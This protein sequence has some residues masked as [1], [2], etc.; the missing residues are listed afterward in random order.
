MRLR[1][2]LIAA[3]LLTH[4]LQ[5]EDARQ[6]E[7]A[8]TDKFVGKVL[9]IRGFYKQNSLDYDSTGEPK[10]KGDPGPW[11]LYG[12]LRVNEVKVRKDRLEIQGTRLWVEWVPDSKGQRQMQLVRTTDDVLLKADLG[13][14]EP[15]PS[16]INHILSSIFLNPED[17][18][19]DLVPEHWRK[20]FGGTVCTSALPE[21]KPQ[22]GQGPGTVQGVS[23]GHLLK[24]ATPAY[25]EQA[26]R[27]RLQGPVVFD[28]VINKQGKVRCLSVW[29]PLGMGAEE[30]SL[31]A[32]RQ[33]TY[34][35]YL[36]NGQP[37]EVQTRITVNYQ[38]TQ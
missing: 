38:L 23:G 35:P 1:V 2:L 33:W 28:V 14:P 34:Q 7:K 36:L 19:S 13:Q 3:V 10:F 8:I 11:T 9:T 18:M 6:I 32:L 20:F 5:A 30:A 27:A 24:R 12:K 16:E 37:V 22:P 29:E 21:F 15:D 4:P 31:D 26:K 25:P 17:R